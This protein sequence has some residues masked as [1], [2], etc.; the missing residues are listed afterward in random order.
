MILASW[1]LLDEFLEISLAFKVTNGS[2]WRNEIRWDW[3]EWF[4]WNEGENLGV[5]AAAKKDEKEEKKTTNFKAAR[6]KKEGKVVKVAFWKTCPWIN[7]ISLI[8]FS[9]YDHH[10]I[11]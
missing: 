8:N 10:V 1:S 2:S 9:K 6:C 3:E 11:E 7:G 4:T 5:I